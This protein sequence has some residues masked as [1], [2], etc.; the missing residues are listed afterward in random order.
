MR[1]ARGWIIAGAVAVLIAIAAYVLQPHNDSPE[2]SS[3]SDAANGTSAAL[4]FAEAMGHPTDQLTGGFE[5][6]ASFSVMFVFSPTSPYTPD[7]AD[8]LRDWVRGRG[9]VLVYASEQGD[10]EL[11]RAFGVVRLQLDVQ[12]APYSALPALGGVT[13]VSGGGDISPLEPGPSQVPVLRTAGG[14]TVGFI[15][16]IGVGSVVVLADPLVLCNG[17]LEKSDNG[18]LLADLLGSNSAAPV[19]FDEYHHGLTVSDFAPQAWLAT[20]WGAALLWLLVAV[21]LGLVLRGRRFGPLIQR[22]PEVVRSDVEWSKAV[23]QLLRR[24]SARAVTLGLLATAT[25]RAVAVRTG[26]SLQP[27]ERFWQALWVRAPEV[28]N[29]LAQVEGTLT[30]SP[31]SERDLLDAARRLH[32]IA[33]PTPRTARR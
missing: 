21:F 1:G 30:A 28:A 27:R 14:W 9:G 11:D 12:G 33:H 18:R 19:T 7:E 5:P 8:R 13:S 31:A 16:R 17:Y 15:E 20:P 23:G 26:L 24:S 22:A 10:A 6:P 32:E 2:H 4:L 29:E 3:N 25:E